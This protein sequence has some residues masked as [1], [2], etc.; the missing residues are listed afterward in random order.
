M[1]FKYL[2]NFLIISEPILNKNILTIFTYILCIN[3]KKSLQKKHY[4]YLFY[5]LKD[6]I[7]VHFSQRYTEY[8]TE[9]HRDFTTF[10]FIFNL[11]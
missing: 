7:L 6:I 8:C 10:I 1:N 3:P 4:L 11:L 2:E 9:L 5:L